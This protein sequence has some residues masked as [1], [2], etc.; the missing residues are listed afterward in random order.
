VIKISS[1]REK[2]LIDIGI[3][4]LESNILFQEWEEISQQR[5]LSEEFIREFQNSLL[6]EDVSYFQILSEDFIR[7]FQTKVSWINISSQQKLS[8]EFLI[9]FKHKIVWNW[10]FRC[11]A[12]SSFIL[13]KFIIKSN[14]QS[15]ELINTGKITNEEFQEIKKILDMKYLFTNI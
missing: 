5:Y 15:L 1:Y 4:K 14:I 9:E 8:D 7:E 6:L 12:P 2:L 3:K 10:Y 13:K 11:Q